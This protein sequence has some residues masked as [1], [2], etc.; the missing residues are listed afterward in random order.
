MVSKLIKLQFLMKNIRFLFATILTLVFASGYSQHTD[1]IN[2]N[3]PGM[4]M[5]AFS[6]GKTVFQV[7]GGLYGYRENHDLAR[8]NSNGM[9]MEMDFRY[10]VLFEQ[11]EVIASFRFQYDKYFSPLVEQTRSGLRSTLIGAKYLIYDPYKNYEEKPN[12]YSWKANHKF[13]WRQLIPA[14][15]GYAGINVGF[16][17]DDYAFPNEPV[18]SPKIMIIGQNQIGSR[19]VLVTNIFYDKITSDYKT[20]GYVVTLTRGFNEKWSGFIENQGFKGDYYSD[21]IFRIGAAYLL[22]DNLQID[23]S[24]SKN[25]KDTPSLFYGGAGIS[26]RF[27][28]KYQPVKIEKEEDGGKRV[29][30]KKKDKKAKEEKKRLDKVDG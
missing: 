30:K 24:I 26:W 12:L 3:R 16:A 8:Y 7:E 10:G 4:S 9:G 25:I 11:L 1:M 23:A 20:L 19:Y 28:K 5:S 18:I 6:V 15:S 29:D 14:V 22:Q 2:S 17:N 27:D 13:K 21:G